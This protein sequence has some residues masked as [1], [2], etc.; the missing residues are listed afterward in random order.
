MKDLKGFAFRAKACVDWATLSLLRLWLVARFKEVQNSEVK[1]NSGAFAIC[2]EY[3][4][5][6]V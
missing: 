6:G 4:G 3:R 5:L 2:C 1:Q